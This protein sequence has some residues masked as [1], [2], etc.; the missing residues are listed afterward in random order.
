M[1]ITPGARHHH[2]PPLNAGDQ[3]GVAAWASTRPAWSEAPL[4][5][6]PPAGYRAA[7][8]VRTRLQLPGGRAV[9][10]SAYRL[11]ASSTL[12]IHGVT[13]LVSGETYRPGV[14][15]LRGVCSRSD[16]VFMVIA[17]EATVLPFP[18]SAPPMRPA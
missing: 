2:W 17:I 10:G 14:E 13:E 7:G 1:D 5:G 8:G 6:E 9:P 12:F 18:S 3:A 16:S 15:A 11:S 4:T